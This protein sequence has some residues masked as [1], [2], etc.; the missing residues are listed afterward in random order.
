MTDDNNVLS[1][2]VPGTRAWFT[3]KD[4]GWISAT[5]TT[6]AIVSD[7]GDV[8]L[9]FALDD[10]EGTR[11]VKTTLAKLQAK[12]GDDVL[13][14]L[15]NPPLL[16][17]TDDLTN[18]SYLNEPAVLHAI[19]N[20][21]SQHLI[22]TYS[23]IV[24]IAVNPFFALNLYSSEIIQA[25][26][27]KRRGELE[28][29]LFAIA[30]DAYRC[31][32][33]DEKD[34]T[35]VVSGESGAGKT[36]SAKYIMRY[37]ATVED[38]DRP[39]SRKQTAGKEVGG[40]SE[41]ERQILAT[42]PIMEAF[43]NAKTTRNDNSSRFGKYIEILFDRNHEIV[44][45]K[46]RTYLLERS[47]LVYQPE[48]ER[49]YHIFYQLCA[50]APASERKELG[51]DD[52]S[53]FKYLNQGGAASKVI[54]GV[55]DAAEFRETQK[56]LGTVGLTSERQ[57]S[58][59]RILAALLH[60]GNTEIGA[61]RNDAMLA[62]DEPSLFLATKLLGIDL[63]EFRKWAVKKQIVTRGEKIVSN[64]TQAQAVVVRDSVSKYIYSCLFDWLVDQ[65]NGSL[66][67]GSTASR[68][69]MI[70]VLDIYG[71]ERF[72]VN[73]F[74][75]FC[76]NYANE[77]L[78]HEFNRHVFKLEQDEYMAEEI[79][80]TFID[81]SDNQPTI[82]MIEGRLGV[83][84]L[85]DE[86]S[87]LPSG[88]DQ[89]FLQKLYTQMDRKP[90]Y[91]NSFKRPRFGQSAFTV[92]HYAL[93]VEYEAEGFL[94]KNR[95]AVPDEH[96]ALLGSTTN[97][98][99]KEVME[100][101]T[102]LANAS[103]ETAPAPGGGAGEDAAKAPA[104][105]RPA[106]GIVKKPTLGS[107]FKLSLVSLMN[108]IDATNVHY[109]R[110]I[111]PNEAKKAWEVEPQNVLGQLRACGVLE[112]IRISCAGYPSRWTFADFA[113]RY[114]MLVPSAHWDMT[115]MDK[116]KELAAYIL[117]SCISDPDKYQIGLNKIFFRAGMLAHFEQR[118]GDRLKTLVTLIQKNLRRNVEMK[119]YQKMRSSSVQLQSW[120]R[121]TAAKKQANGMR[122]ERAAV[123]LQTML[124]AWVAQQAYQRTRTAVVRIQAIAR[125]R[126]TRA[127]Y[128]DNKITFAAVRLQSLFRGYLGRR[129]FSS[130]RKG[131]VL[132]QS[133]YRRRLAKRELVHLRN[134]A[135]SAK[136]YKEVTYKLENKVVELTQNLS[137]RTKENKDL[138]AK[139][140]ALE[141]S[142]MEWQGKH[143]DVHT[144][145][146]ALQT[147]LD[148]PSVPAEEF[149]SLLASKR[150]LDAQH[151]QAIQKVKEHE[152]R[153]A[154][155]EEEVRR[156]AEE[157]E[158]RD[159][160]LSKRQ[161]E[162]ST[163][164]T[165]L[166]AEINK[167]RDELARAQSLNQL[168][169]NGDA[170]PPR[171]GMA[172]K[173]GAAEY[174]GLYDLAMGKDGPVS[175][176][177]PRRPQR[178]R[179][180]DGAGIAGNHR[181]AQAA[182][183]RHVSVMPPQAQTVKDEDAVA[184]E[185]E[186]ILLD[187]AQ[188]DE[189]LL[190]GLIQ[191]LPVP[192]G[193]DISPKEC[194]FPSHLIALVLNEYW[195]RSMIRP[196]E[197]VLANVM[198]TIQSHVMGLDGDDLIT[199]SIYWISNVHELLSFVSVAES[200][201]LA[202][203]TPGDNEQAFGD[204]ERL[205]VLAKHDL[206]SLEYNIYHT[207]IDNTKRRLHKMVVPA[208]IESQS[209]PGFVEAS[210][211]RLFNRL[212][213]STTNNAP[214]FNM[215][216][217]LSVLNVVWKALKTYYLEA[218]VVHQVI[219]ELMRL[220]NSTAFN[221]LVLRRSFCSWKRAMQIQYNITRLEEWCKA[222]GIPEAMLQLEHLSQSVKLLQLKKSTLGDIDIIYDV[223]WVLTPSQI[224]KLISQYHTAEY[225]QPISP[226]ILKAAA[227]RVTPNDRNDHLLLPPEV[228][229]AGPYELPMPREVT[230][231]ETYI[232][233]FIQ[234]PSL[235]RLAGLVA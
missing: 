44:G 221:D 178:P 30:E 86:E 191:H 14:P 97:G 87:R 12:G 189:D 219:T 15:R 174:N 228:D 187:E 175:A 154:V 158:A 18:L 57:W 126:A 28:P 147:E 49:N 90:E 77:R 107:Q 110:C 84:S 185:I 101:A 157:L 24:L 38:P 216:Q 47:R 88:S 33:R 60:L 139:V 135:K 199:Q 161:D 119:R 29:H 23:G 122:Q 2:Y 137:K 209:L 64:L 10:S 143:D 150:E 192:M 61:T 188:L 194:L 173:G 108:T 133:C 123:L 113:E 227:A 35:I 183:N 162:D 25:Y 42:N 153:I 128:A 179:S 127:K 125:G 48:N 67:L 203:V 210:S 151:D 195:L 160:A 172:G 32:I 78:Q 109:I 140:K 208:V 132:L 115:S 148:K 7:N 129:R 69:S 104:P 27:G 102:Q 145:S 169:G 56:A 73:S 55:D 166:R 196:S 11:Q 26:S 72:K 193:D 190:M 138:V 40:M 82:D 146:R 214:A 53:H 116:A 65:L 8:V 225:E 217:V 112:T 99:L 232:P 41:T 136:H 95:D 155:L 235:R 120:W 171:G 204:Y 9:E 83:L 106:G 197:R 186:V 39:G 85:L 89:S 80:W 201:L 202:G 54:N 223:S 96:L 226:E 181:K 103:K 3:D 149:E 222:K 230:G 233:A 218:A 1:A 130:D 50:G 168:S 180:A 68:K 51:L 167:L 213:S 131:I 71:F 200:D 4:L 43:G 198:Q 134:E 176:N 31:M 6:K 13:P 164:A 212:I 215:E 94:E 58:I 182:A 177:G 22:Y 75:Q 16:E 45:A 156:G 105:R 59:F 229:E 5:Q 152:D 124:R 117:K 93:D 100:T 62:Q 74:E 114:Y 121:M 91:K 76:I 141:A 165:S 142:V 17:A 144:K 211:G 184:E 63:S 231:I 37:F 163:T 92:C 21:Y 159:G 20:R 66:A 220:I 205:I 52:A 234:A 98:F 118:R 224:H 111:K 19:L 79:S 36:V 170:A 81:F 207:L 70:G 34:Q 206:E 46:I